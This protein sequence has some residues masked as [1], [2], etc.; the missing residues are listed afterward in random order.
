MTIVQFG[1]RSWGL[2][3]GRAYSVDGMEVAIGTS[4]NTTE[5]DGQNG[6]NIAGID[7]VGVSMDVQASR[8]LGVSPLDEL[9]ALYAL[10]TK[11]TGDRL[12]ML[13]QA[14]L[15]LDFILTDVEMTDVQ[16]GAAGIETATFHLEFTSYDASAKAKETSTPVTGYASG[17]RGGGGGGNK[18]PPKDEEEKDAQETRDQASSHIP[19]TFVSK[20]VGGLFKK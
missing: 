6:V 16:A 18:K 4:Q 14:L 17:K 3:S 13:G 15:N 19:F 20:V 8:A 10:M 5:K 12:Y 7:P 2:V 9:S 1:G 11:K